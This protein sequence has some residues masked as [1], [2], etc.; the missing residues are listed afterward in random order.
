[1]NCEIRLTTVIS[2]NTEPLPKFDHIVPLFPY[3]TLP[4][5]ILTLMVEIS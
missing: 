4:K 5:K 3:S 1:M 2:K